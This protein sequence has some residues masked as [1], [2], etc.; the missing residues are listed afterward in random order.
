MRDCQLDCAEQLQEVS[1]ASCWLA[2]SV[3]P[4]KLQDMVMYT[5]D[6]SVDV[7]PQLNGS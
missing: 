3:F 2:G 7:F 5:V 6:I 1:E 4:E